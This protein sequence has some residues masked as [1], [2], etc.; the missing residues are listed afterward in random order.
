MG[1]ILSPNLGSLKLVFIENLLQKFPFKWIDKGMGNYYHLKDW[2][3]FMIL[4]NQNHQV[5][6]INISLAMI[7]CKIIIR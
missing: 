5:Y 7:K 4:V 2:T 1:K 3:I 6:M